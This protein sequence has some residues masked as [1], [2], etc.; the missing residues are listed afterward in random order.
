MLPEPR[1]QALARWDNEGG[2]GPN[3]PQ[4][5]PVEGLGPNGRNPVPSTP[6]DAVPLKQPPAA[7]TS[8]LHRPVL[9]L[10]QSQSK[11]AKCR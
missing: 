10:R 2:A 6:V 11:E 1:V 4:D 8:N 3:G 9:H 7:T 5:G